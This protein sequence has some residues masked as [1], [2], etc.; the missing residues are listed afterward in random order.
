MDLTPYLPLIFGLLVTGV[1]AGLMAGLLGI[2]GGLVLVPVLFYVFSSMT[3]NVVTALTTATATSLAIIVP[4]S[5]SSILAHYRQKNIDKALLKKWWMWIL[6]GV[7]CATGLINWLRG[8]W[9]QLVFSVFAISMGIKMLLQRKGPAVPSK[10]WR[11]IPASTTPWGIGLISTLVGIGGGTLTVPALTSQGYLMSRAIG[12]SAAVGFIIALPAA[13]TLLFATP[14]A[15]PVPFTF[16]LVNL[17]AFAC[18]A[19][20]ATLVA[21]IGAKWSKR[22][23]PS[24]LKKVFAIILIITGIR[25]AFQL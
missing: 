17:A 21:P 19:P 23:K 12:T 3:D 4:T 7:L 11:Y 13:T 9:I 15:N 6:L 2:G 22:V 18:T 10:M 14:P 20:L 1:F 8:P 5:V 25:I 24:T 16:G